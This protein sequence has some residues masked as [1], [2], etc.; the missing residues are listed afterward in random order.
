LIE[1]DVWIAAHSGISRPVFA[2]STQATASIRVNVQE[3]PS[4][5]SGFVVLNGDPTTPPLINPDG[6][7]A[8][9]ASFEI[10]NPN[11]SNPNISNP[12]ISNP[13]ISNPNISN[14]NISNPIIPNPNISNPN[15]SNPNISNPNISN[16]NISNPNIS[17]PNISN[18]NISNMPVSDATYVLT[19]KGNTAA[20]YNVNLVGN[21]PANVPL[22]LI[23]S[24]P[25]LTPVAKD[26]A[27]KQ[28]TQNIVLANITSPNISNPNISNPNISNPNISNVTLALAPGESVFV[29]LRG[30]NV[31]CCGTTPPPGGA[32]MEEIVETVAPVAASHAANTND[33]TNTPPVAAPLFITT[34][35]LPDGI[36]GQPYNPT[37]QAIGGTAPYAWSVVLGSLPNGL[38][39]DPSTGA[40][41]GTP[42]L[43]G[44]YSFTV[45]VVDSALPTP[46]TATRSLGM[47]V[48]PPPLP[49]LVVESLTHSPLTPTTA[50]L[51]T[52]TAVV[53]N[54]GAGPAGA[55]TLLFKIG[56]ETPGSP[57]TLFQ[58][59]P[60]AAGQSFTVQRQMTLTA[61]NYRNTAIADDVNNAVVESNESN[62]EKTD[63]YTVVPVGGAGVANLIFTVQPSNTTGA[64]PISPPVQV[65]A[66]DSGGAVVP[67][68]SI[69]MT[70][71]TNPTGGTLSGTTTATTGADGI[72]TFSNL[73][74]DRGGWGYTLV[75]SSGAVTSLPSTAFD[76]VGFAPT[77]GSLN[78]A[79]K[80]YTATLL[81]NGMV[82]I[83]GGYNN[84]YLAS[85]E[86]Y[87]P[88]AKTFTATTHSMS[89]ARRDHTAML[90]NNGMVLIA[91]GAGPGGVSASAELYDPAT[92]T[93]TPTTHSLNTAR[94]MHTATLLND[95]MVLIAGGFAGGSLASAE[96]YD[97]AAGTF[98][99]T[100]G[101]LN[102]GRYE[103]T[104]TLLNNGMV[105][106]AGGIDPIPAYL[107]SAEL[108]DP[109]AGTF[110]P[111]TNSLSTARGYH[112]ATLLNNGLVLMA[113]GFISPGGY[114]ASADLYDPATKTFTPTTGS[115]NSPRSDHTAT[116]LNNG[117]VLMAGGRQASSSELASAE[118]YNPATG[119]FTPTGSLNTGRY[120]HKATLLNNRLVLMVG[121]GWG[122]GDAL[123]SAE[124]FYP[125]GGGAALFVVQPS[126]VTVGE[127]FVP[128]VRVMARDSTGAALSGVNITLAIG[129]QPPPGGGPLSGTTTATTDGTGVATFTGLTVNGNTG[130]GFTLVASATGSPSA[131]STAFSV[132]PVRTGSVMD[133]VGDITGTNGDL[134]S[135][136]ITTAV[137]GSA[138]Q[139]TVRFA[140]GTFDPST[141]EAEVLLDTDQNP[142]TG[143]KGTDSVCAPPDDSLIG[144]E[145]LVVLRSGFAGNTATIFQNS[146]AN[147]C[148]AFVVVGTVPVTILADGL[149]ATVPLSMLG[150]DDGLMNFKVTSD[151]SIGG[152]NFS[153]LVD[154][155]PNAG[156]A[157]ASTF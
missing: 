137:P 98:T 134:V 67:G 15:I 27:L 29:T 115:L 92:G 20:S 72:A 78:T 60:L 104:A 75:A 39:L 53:K 142:A 139:F 54:V 85:A 147:T 81:N 71:E 61:Q 63:D 89:T 30:N 44:T 101:P 1:L 49:D 102:T 126:N 12:N 9:V 88:A 132:V 148:N 23:V 155:M 28:E 3:V 24:K 79:R 57:Q 21:A 74:I 153:G 105:L 50:D 154:R 97:P 5:L 111:T 11:I 77:G 108:Y 93:F 46:H 32:T 16:P 66:Q 47:Q 121:G 110:T 157:P 114:L 35:A 48:A 156:I 8:D 42:T 123:A 141:T 62:N 19:N 34:A 125:A 40:I 130:T 128:A 150:N 112:T 117:L 146:P 83:A 143:H 31:T 14:P 70:I 90:L 69:T 151:Y 131:T 6:S 138:M 87:D 25:Y 113:G 103:H 43:A 41:I 4:G 116:L 37:L 82:L 22:Q 84:G 80:F 10:Y 152:N 13:N 99:P 17:N 68:A 86:L 140:P 109:A 64:Q 106:M 124:L 52:F 56:G 45:Q 58:V 65:K 18:P 36:T 100:T 33:T 127:P 26:C 135:A 120:W 144:S 136:S 7:P 95:G 55:S 122:S 73:Q 129:S 38:G 107:A 91:G 118:L 119:T 96:L 133:P 145:F 51:I 76:V 94:Y 149:Q 2:V 59:P